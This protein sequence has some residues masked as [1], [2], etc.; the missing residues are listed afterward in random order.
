MRTLGLFQRWFCLPRSAPYVRTPTAPNP[1]TGL[2][3]FPEYTYETSPYYV[4][5]NLKNQWGPWAILNRIRG[6][7]VPGAKYDSQGIAWESMGAKR[8]TEEK[9]L[10]AENK[11]RQQAKILMEADWGFRASVPFQPRP[12]VKPLGLGYGSRDNAFPDDVQPYPPPS[13]K[14]EYLE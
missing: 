13:T 9:Q 3:N 12:M 1:E 6:I 4:R 5:P 7:G 8:A 11:V 10:Q 2:F 14:S